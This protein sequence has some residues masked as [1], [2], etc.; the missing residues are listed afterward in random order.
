M[1]VREEHAER[2]RG[3]GAARLRRRLQQVASALAPRLCAVLVCRVR[4]VNRVA[5]ADSKAVLVVLL[6]QVVVVRISVSSVSSSTRKWLGVE[7]ARRE[8]AGMCVEHVAREALGDG[9]LLV[10]AERALGLQDAGR[11]GHAPEEAPDRVLVAT[12]FAAT[13]ALLCGAVRNG[14]LLNEE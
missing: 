2:R 9:R 1:F 14:Q 8:E 11:V 3:R 13:G 4:C 6:V 10:A 5:V 7:E 12:D